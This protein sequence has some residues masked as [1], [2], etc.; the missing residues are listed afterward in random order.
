[1]SPRARVELDLRVISTTHLDLPALV[2]VGKFR[3]DLYYRPAVI[4]LPLPSLHER[5]DDIMLLA[6]SDT[7]RRGASG[8]S[9]PGEL[10]RHWHPSCRFAGI[11]SSGA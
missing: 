3:E 7:V 11:G 2:A 1:V 5:P 8:R 6:G 4:P 9:G 10:C